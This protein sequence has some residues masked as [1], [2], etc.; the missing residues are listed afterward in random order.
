M[1]IK[2]EDFQ[3]VSNIL[4]ELEGLSHY[5]ID[6]ILNN[7]K[8]NIY[9]NTLFNFNESEFNDRVNKTIKSWTKD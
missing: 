5:K 2:K 4:K 3:K 9:L 1:I 8:R 7:V 6:N